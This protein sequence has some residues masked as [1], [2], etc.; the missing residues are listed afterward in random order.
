MADSSGTMRSTAS[1]DERIVEAKFDTSD[2]E[3]GVDK[4]IK[5]LDELKESLNLK[6]AGKSIGQVAEE[7]KKIVDEFTEDGTKADILAYIRDV[8]DRRKKEMEELL[9]H[10]VNM[11]I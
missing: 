6:D 11:E 1:V 7:T 2:F 4:T 5:K 3:K 10:L 9:I 8:L